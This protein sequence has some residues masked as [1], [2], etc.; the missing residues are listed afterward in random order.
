VAPESQMERTVASVWQE[1][2][3]VENVG[4]H[5]NFFDLGGH[6][7]LLIRVHSK[8]RDV[9]S[10]DVSMIEMFRYPTVSSLAM[11]LGREISQQPSFAQIHERANKQKEAR[12]RQNQLSKARV[13][14]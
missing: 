14:R 1:V 12:R 11:Y 13:N 4:L 10:N 9:L 3:Q 5:D 8:L 6:S 2:L 7:L